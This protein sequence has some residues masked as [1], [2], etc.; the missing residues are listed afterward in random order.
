MSSTI[1]PIADRLSAVEE[2]YFSQKLQEI[3]ERNARGEDVINLGIGSPDLMP[4]EEVIDQLINTAASPGVHGYQ[5]YRG[6]PQLRNAFADW[7]LDTYGVTLNPEKEILPLMGSKEGIMHL[8]MAFLNPG[9]EVLVPNPGYPTYSSA[10]KV[11]GGVIRN[12]DLKHENGWFPDLAALEA[13]GLEKVK[14]M[15]VNYPHMPTGTRATQAIF[16]ELVAFAQ[17]NRIL[18]CHDNPYSLVL[19]P[20]PRSILSVPGSMEVALEINSLSKSHNMAGWR[21]GMLAGS[22][23]HLNAALRV[24][25]NMDSGMFYALQMA[26]ATALKQPADWHET[27]NQVYRDRRVVAWQIMDDLGC[28]VDKNQ[29]GMFIWA[30]IPTSAGSGQHLSEEI[31]NRAGVFLTP[32]FIF[33]DTGNQY[34]R[35][36]LCSPVEVLEQ[37]KNRVRTRFLETIA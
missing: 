28:E 35:L 36:S 25:S 22:A 4:A 11:A 12:Y 8:S 31:L 18:L 17:R 23:A 6:I 1:I 24:K 20:E 9:D 5:S 2:Y 32:G 14:M 19:N 33:G 26:A 30:K 34:I 16:E 21:V 10:A 13:Q 29:V 7:Y 37:A 3:R 15:W 27:R